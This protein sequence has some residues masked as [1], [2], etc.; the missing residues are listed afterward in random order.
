MIPR[1]K[2]PIYSTSE[3]YR[4][5]SRSTYLKRFF[6]VSFIFDWFIGL[7]PFFRCKEDD[8]SFTQ[9][10]AR[11]LIHG[12]HARI[13][14]RVFGVRSEDRG[15]GGRGGPGGGKREI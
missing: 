13:L 15:G 14:A 8:I 7:G 5:K 2:V 6:K 10:T 4:S 12:R 1:Q 3:V 9:L 11:F